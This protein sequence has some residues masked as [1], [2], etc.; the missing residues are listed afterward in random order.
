MPTTATP[1]RGRRRRRPRAWGRLRCC[2][3]LVRSPRSPRG[4]GEAMTD[5]SGG[6]DEHVDSAGDK[7]VVARLEA[8]DSELA[9]LLAERAA[10]LANYDAASP[11]ARLFTRTL[12]G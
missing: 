4:S 8:I 1:D 11:I 6:A 10:I 12:V 3:G 7:E 9:A 5:E 2:P